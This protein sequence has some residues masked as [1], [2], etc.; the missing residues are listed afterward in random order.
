M[1]NSRLRNL[2]LTAVF[3]ALTAVGAFVRIGTVTLQVFF[4]CTAG[5]LL[6]PVWGTA[7]QG[8]YVLLGLLGLPLF[9]HGGWFM[10]VV[11]P[12]FG[13][14][15]GLLPLAAVTGF[16]SRY[17]RIPLYLCAAGGLV[18]LYAVALPYFYFV[19]GAVLP[20]R[21]L[22]LTACAPYLPFD[23]LKLLSACMLGQRL[24]YL[25]RQD[26]RF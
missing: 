6:G 15:L 20:L 22:F 11:Q 17:P 23:G 10:Y 26:L 9:T 16:L 4:A 25:L 19:T 1:K 8:L 21:E 5:M 24:R 12:T 18:A 14:L 2:L 3:A 13:F 7:S